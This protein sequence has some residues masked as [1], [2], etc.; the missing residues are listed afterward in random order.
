M[1]E[2]LLSAAQYMPHGYCLAWRPELVA[3]HLVSDALIAVSYFSIPA[4]IYYF[5][6]QKPDFGYRWLAHGFAA[7][8]ICCGLT[9]LFGLM[10]LWFPYYGLEGMMKA[11]TAL[12]SVVTAICL[13]PLIPRILAIP[14][15][16]ELQRA[17]NSLLVEVEQRRQIEAEL[18]ERLDD[19]E[20]AKTELTDM[21]RDNQQA[22]N[23]A[24]Q[25]DRSK[26]AFLRNVCHEL[27]T[28][29][30]AILG[31]SDLMISGIYGKL[32]SARYEEYL[33]VIHQSGEHLLSLLTDLIDLDQIATGHRNIEL[34]PVCIATV[35]KEAAG[36][37]QPRAEAKRIELNNE[38]PENVLVN[39]DRMAFKQVLINLISNA[40]KYTPDGGRVDVSA[41]REGG[42]VLIKVADN[43]IGIE[44]GDIAKLGQVFVRGGSEMVRQSE[45]SGLG[46]AVCRALLEQ[47]NG[48][49]SFDSVPQEGTTVTV[50]LPE[51]YQSSAVQ[52]SNAQ[53]GSL[54]AAS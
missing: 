53:V 32:A 18:E 29:L 39:A 19:L 24:E 2:S 36:M 31:Y 9:H 52:S 1:L 11:A 8:I 35:S 48:A 28:P 49:I 45:G 47:M 37:V 30:N 26:T 3:V 14:S 10:T 27:R 50:A 43:G 4:G 23:L 12:V 34:E 16:E 51:A 13:W 33:S 17:N 6:R 46:L 25:A 42:N 20:K 21:A 22:R 15:P 7:F 54:L 40:V 38:I 5:L 41:V 44:Q